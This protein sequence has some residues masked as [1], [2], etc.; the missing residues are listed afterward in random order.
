MGTP[1]DTSHAFQS[2]FNAH[3]NSAVDAI[4]ES[5]FPQLQDQVYL[6]HAGTTIPSRVAVQAFARQATQQVWGN[7]HSQNGPA[8]RTAD[9]IQWVRTRILDTFN[10]TELDYSVVFTANATAGLKLVGESFPWAQHVQQSKLGSRNEAHG[11]TSHF[12]F[13]QQA[14]TSVVGIR[15]L[16]Y[17]H[18]ARVRS[19][20][21]AEI[22]SWIASVAD[23][24]PS[25]DELPAG[26][27][28][29]LAY[30]A[31][32][33]FSGTR[34]P[35]AWST[36]I[37]R[38]MSTET[39]PSGR[40]VTLL[41][42]ASYVTTAPLDL[43]RSKES[44]DLVVVSF[45]KMFGFPTGLGALLIKN[46][47][48]PL[49]TKRY[50]G[51]GS[52]AAIAYDE[53][54]QQ[55]RAQISDRLEDGT[56]NFM[57]IVALRSAYERWA[58]LFPD[59][60]LVTRHT[61]SLTAWGI[62]QLAQ[63]RH[64][65][66]HSVCQLYLEPEVLDTVVDLGLTAE[67]LPTTMAKLAQRQG[68]IL[69]LNLRR[70]DGSW[71]GYT[72][73]ARLANLSRISLRA[74]GACNPGAMHRWLQLDAATVKANLDQGHV[75]WDNHDLID[76]RPTGALRI[77]FGAMS[78]FRDLQQWLS[79]IQTHFVETT[80]RPVV[81]Q[82]RCPLSAT[83][84]Y[85]TIHATAALASLTIFPIKSCRGM[86]IGS[87]KRWPLAPY[88]L[89]HDREWMLVDARTGRALSQKR[90]PR[91][92][93]IQPT[94]DLHTNRLYVR[95]P[96]RPTLAVS[97]S[98]DAEPMVSTDCRVCGTM[99]VSQRYENARITQWFSA[100]LGFPCH[101]V[102][103]ALPSRNTSDGGM[104]TPDASP[105]PVAPL[106]LANESPFLL[107]SQASVDQVGKWMT[108]SSEPSATTALPM[109]NA[110]TPIPASRFRGNFVIQGSQLASFAEDQA[111]MVRIGDQYFEISKP[112]NRCQMVSIDQETGA[113]GK[114]PFTTLSLHR[115]VKE[116]RLSY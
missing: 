52:V 30:P 98:L 68:P 116:W 61:A 23:K 104:P 115:K 76:G 89:L 25:S 8:Q 29:L 109:S 87:S 93:L 40:W 34:F 14:H 100:F 36:A 5:D 77:S 32:C 92:C 41:D 7:P 11:A 55:Y 43:S 50:F 20:T 35:L 46:S 4:M 9:C 21:E 3:Y 112:C 114:E 78:T 83:H 105:V 37:Q 86:A 42:A 12:W 57:D 17:H 13:L 6:D 103:Q 18:G 84:A 88:G 94:I 113:I 26:P 67:R 2:A 111:N 110:K 90:Y 44:A 81:V 80:P 79:F 22:N 82:A 108:L 91:M 75:C 69:C 74:G 58:I 64:F 71:V 70:A 10:T 39:I 31:Q 96:D 16:A 95:A 107:I 45:Y 106:L 99:T 27:V 49:L 47:V 85:P 15:E 66:G 63:L 53:P 19:F 97:L 101:L 38:C 56:V 1:F 59:Q 33:N 24:E 51:G 65:N 48:A 102:R 73:V 72:E 62:A 54:W 28:H 60:Q